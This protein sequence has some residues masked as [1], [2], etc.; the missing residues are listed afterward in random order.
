MVVCRNIKAC[1]ESDD[2]PALELENRRQI[3]E[4]GDGK[5]SAFAWTAA[6][7]PLRKS[8]STCRPDPLDRPEQV[9]QWGKIVW[10][11]IKN[12]TG[13]LLIEEFGIRMPAF[14]TSAHEKSG[15]SDRRSN[16]A[17]IEQLASRL[18]CRTKE[19]V[20]RTTNPD[21][22]GCGNAEQ[23]FGLAGG[24][25]KRFLRVD[26]FTRPQG[27]SSYFHVMLRSG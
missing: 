8:G 16:G 12:R 10:S 2:R 15:S 25:A 21:A 7:R 13:S 24:D 1:D 17:F 26:V 19:G 6:D 22:V 4:N 20:R 23:R 5:R 3:A 14:R 27:G 18:L 9:H 11:H